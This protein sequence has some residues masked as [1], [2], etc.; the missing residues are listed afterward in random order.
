VTEIE[1]TGP[2]LVQRLIADAW[3]TVRTHRLEESLC[4]ICRVPDCRERTDAIGYLVSKG[5]WTPENGN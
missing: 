3:S 1:L 2:E 4:L 5:E